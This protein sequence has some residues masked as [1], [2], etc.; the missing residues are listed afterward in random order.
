MAAKPEGFFTNTNLMI[1]GIIC[2][3]IG[4][5]L[6]L[7]YINGRVAQATGNPIEV[8]FAKKDINTNEVC[9]EDSIKWVDLPQRFIDEA[10][11]KFVTKENVTAVLKYSPSRRV[12]TTEP[13]LTT[14]FAT[15][16]EES[17]P[18][19]PYPGMVTIIVG[20]SPKNQVGEN[21]N[22]G[23]IITLIGNFDF[24]A[25]HK[26][27]P[28]TLILFDK[29]YVAAINGKTKPSKTD[30]RSVQQVSIFVGEANSRL[31][32][33]LEQFQ[34]GDGKFDVEILPPKTPYAEVRDQ[35]PED[36]LRAIR[37]ARDKVAKDK[38]E[39]E[40][41]DKLKRDKVEKVEE[42]H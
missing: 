30:R 5:A 34:V 16:D 39:K 26:S 7:V 42:K 24:S 21:I 38:A 8:A 15:G 20:I 25:D 40:R 10:G 37:E 41:E 31:R 32:T 1:A 12:E 2:A 6:A 19:S 35:V 3:V 28:H 14:E 11:G 29:V 33:E 22:I 18:P 36:T 4:A 9:R 17:P 27:D 13:L 23:S